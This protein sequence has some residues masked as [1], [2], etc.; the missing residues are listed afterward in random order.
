MNFRDI[1][2]QNRKLLSGYTQIKEYKYTEINPI[3]IRP[4]NLPN[5]PHQGMYYVGPNQIAPAIPKPGLGSGGV[6]LNNYIGRNY[7][8]DQLFQQLLDRRYGVGYYG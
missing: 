6:N 4:Q 7:N 2:E 8:T 3:N 5:W 1:A